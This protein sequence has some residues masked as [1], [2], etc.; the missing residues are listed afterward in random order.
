METTT[1]ELGPVGFWSLKSSSFS[2]SNSTVIEESARN[3]STKVDGPSA[4]SA[5]GAKNTLGND[6][7]TQKVS[8]NDITKVTI[9]TFQNL[10]KQ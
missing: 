7:K 4:N 8:G 1:P 5:Q 6:V 9:L 2:G 3:G 10:A